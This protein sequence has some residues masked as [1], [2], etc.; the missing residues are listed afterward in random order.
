VLKA[1][2][3]TM[4]ATDGHRLAHIENTEAKFTGVSGENKTLI[5]RKAMAELNALLADTEEP[6]VHFAKDESTLFFKVG[7]R[8]MTS[9][10]LTGQFPNYEAVLPRENN[11]NVTI[12]SAQLSAALQRVAQFADERSGAVRMK[13]EKDEVR[14]SASS[15]ESGESE[16]SIETKYSADPVTIGFNSAYMLDFLKAAGGGNIMLEF[17]DSQSAGQLRP[18]DP[19]EGWRYRYVVMPMRI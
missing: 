16:D 8:V 10:Q 2:S 3:M 17:K 4:V 6:F 12:D 11:K 1:E 13:L 5:P 7:D 9:R 19:A 14:I 15:Q 18:A